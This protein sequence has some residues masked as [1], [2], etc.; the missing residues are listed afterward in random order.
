MKASGHLANI[1]TIADTDN[2]NKLIAQTNQNSIDRANDQCTAMEITP[3]G[4]YPGKILT[5][6]HRKLS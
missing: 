3:K 2:K 5:R 6:Y 1:L 4:A